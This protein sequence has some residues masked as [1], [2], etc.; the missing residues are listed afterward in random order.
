M[1]FKLTIENPDLDWKDLKDMITGNIDLRETLKA[2]Y[3]KSKRRKRLGFS[4]KS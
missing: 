2:C 3:K 1:R 4:K